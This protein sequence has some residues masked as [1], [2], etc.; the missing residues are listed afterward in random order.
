MNLEEMRVHNELTSQKLR[1]LES[2][3][4]MLQLPF[5]RLHFKQ[6]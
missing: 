2:K 3:I 4:D 5:D 6:K 1:L